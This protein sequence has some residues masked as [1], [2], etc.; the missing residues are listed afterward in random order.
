[1][2]NNSSG[3]AATHPPEFDETAPVFSLLRATSRT[4]A[5]S[6]EGLPDRL[7]DQIAVSYLL[8]RV[9]DYLEDHESVPAD[10]KVRLLRLWES[11]LGGGETIDRF[12]TELAS[13]PHRDDDPEAQV[14]R[15]AGLLV[16]TA[17]GF[18]ADA[19]AVIVERV[20]ETT[21]GMARW[22]EK[23]PSVED[24]SEL[25]D[26]M[27]HVA[28]LVGYLVTDLFS[29]HFASVADRRS[30]LMPLAREFGLALQCVNILRGLRKDYERGW[31]FVPR[32][33]CAA[34]DL[35]ATDLFRRSERIRA[36]RVVA[37]LVEKAEHHL[38][39]GLAYV[40][41]LPRRL[42]RLRLACMWPLLFAARTIAATR[43]NPG[44]LTGEV[45][46]SR[47]TVRRIVRNSTVFG[48]SNAWLEAYARRLLSARGAQ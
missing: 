14:A 41:M 25:D 4:F 42:H 45:K 21:R 40:R 13:V 23:G 17:R 31:I 35:V 38:R 20:C 37:D 18:P 48:W 24:E 22:Q 11:T 36:M 2:M 29:L 46:I 47:T 28:G 8:L 6:I 15:C 44:V 43:G 32:T 16:D 30:L 27:H 5:L 1:M 19:R 9:S 34:H 3:D 12:E 7:R 39:S 10:E 26:Y 33:F